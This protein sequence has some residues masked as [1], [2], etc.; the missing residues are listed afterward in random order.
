MK[1]NQKKAAIVTGASS[2][3]GKAIAEMLVS[4][5]YEVFGFGREFTTDATTGNFADDILEGKLAAEDTDG[6]FHPIVCDLLDTEVLERHIKQIRKQYEI[7]I[8]VNNAGVGYYGLH[9][10]LNAAKIKQM[11][12]TNLELPLILSNLLLR[13]LK[14][15]KGYLLQI[16]SVTALKNSPHGCAYGATK[17]GLTAFS[18]SLFEEA[19]KYGVKVTVIHP[20]MTQTNLYR[21]ADFTAAEDLQASLCPE[22]VAE[23]VHFV[24]TARDGMVIPE[25]TLS[26]QLHRI[27]KKKPQ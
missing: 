20:D 7:Y 23:A 2:G 19:R 6:A 18:R 22:D 1:E 5:G 26:P 13:D 21:N 9:E 16:S 12:R 15:S 24:L 3:I 17:A 4:L 27:S 10:E 8:L 11:V 25:L 14:K